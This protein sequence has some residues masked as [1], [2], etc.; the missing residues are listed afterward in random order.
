MCICAAICAA[1]CY[2][3][4]TR[5]TQRIQRFT[6]LIVDY[7]DRAQRG[8]P[9]Q[10]VSDLVAAIDYEAWLH[11][12]SHNEQSAERRVANVFDLLAWMKRL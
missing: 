2:L 10:T 3:D 11:D 7:S 5:E 9:V 6:Q 8:D 4:N 1:L 12:V